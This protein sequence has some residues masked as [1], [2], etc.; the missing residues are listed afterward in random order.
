MIDGDIPDSGKKWPE[1]FE[2]F[3]LVI[4][5][6]VNWPWHVVYEEGWDISVNE[7]KEIWAQNEPEDFMYLL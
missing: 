2:A 1:V 6:F 4:Q 5:G 7:T 3:E